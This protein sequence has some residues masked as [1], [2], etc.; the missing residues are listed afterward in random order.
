[1]IA[2]VLDREQIRRIHA[3]SLHILERVGID[4]PHPDMLRR[5][6]DAGAVVDQ[7]RQRVRIPASLVERALAQA[8]KTFTLYGR[9]LAQ[10]ARFGQG[11]RNYNS[12][13]GEANWVDRIGGARRL[14]P[15]PHVGTPGPCR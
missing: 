11:T 14:A 1:M 5:F 2:Q 7:A 9:D 3:A 12:I 10:M 15:L 13:A 4:L 6:A 8:G